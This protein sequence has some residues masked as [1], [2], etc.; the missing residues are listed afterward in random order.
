MAAPTGVTATALP[1]GIPA[2]PVVRISHF[3]SMVLFA[4]FASVA[5]ACI[6]MRGRGMERVK[7]AAR[8]LFWFLA[9]AVA[10]A[11]LMYPFSR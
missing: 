11:W 9:A 1:S 4:V 3:G 6:G 10:I 7:Y 2:G 8:T 5:L